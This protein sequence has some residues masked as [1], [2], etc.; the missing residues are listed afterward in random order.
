MKFLKAL[1]SILIDF[2][3][4]EAVKQA[5]INL[6]K[7]GAFLGFRTWLVR[8]IVIHL[9]DEVAKPIIDLSFRK[10]GYLVEVKNGEYLLKKIQNSA[11]VNDWS[12]SVN[13]V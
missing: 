2:L 13:G 11:D 12:N 7:S 9:F 10:V 1:K 3:R 8:I 5:L 4:K 6:V